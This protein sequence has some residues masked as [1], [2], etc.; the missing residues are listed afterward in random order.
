MSCEQSEDYA[1]TQFGHVL[2]R[3]LVGEK[4]QKNKQN[5]TEYGPTWENN[6]FVKIH[7]WISGKWSNRRTLYDMENPLGGTAVKA[8][9][10]WPQTFNSLGVNS[11]RFI[12][13]AQS[14]LFS[15]DESPLFLLLLEGRKKIIFWQ[16]KS[17]VADW[18]SRIGPILR[19]TYTCSGN[20]NPHENV[21]QEGQAR[22]NIRVQEM[23]CWLVLL[24]KMSSALPPYSPFTL[25][26][27]IVIGK[28]I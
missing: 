16:Q 6:E 20:L 19:S 17:K 2:Q 27:L 25:P 24:A 13:I 15:Q 3:A 10:E 11:G 4:K 22:D 1:Y 28:N 9:R 12:N 18:A 8:H 23:A 7:S 5:K 26:L 21:K 14:E